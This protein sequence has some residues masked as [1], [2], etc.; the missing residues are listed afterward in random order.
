MCDFTEFENTIYDS[1]LHD[2]INGNVMCMLKR[3]ENRDVNKLTKDIIIDYYFHKNNI[4]KE[5]YNIYS[6]KYDDIISNSFTIINNEKTNIIN[7][8][9]EQFTKYYSDTEWE[10]DKELHYKQYFGR[11]KDLLYIIEY[12]EKLREEEENKIYVD[13]ISEDYNEDNVNYLSDEEYYFSD[14]YYL[15]EEEDESYDDYYDY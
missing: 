2:Y 11:Y 7:N 4:P 3:N 10:K 15:D 8:D 14:E 9:S 1:S 13:E 6:K 12:Y 5:N